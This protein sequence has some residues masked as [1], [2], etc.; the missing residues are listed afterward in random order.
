[1]AFEGD[2]FHD[3]Q[4]LKRD[5]VRSANYPATSRT[6][7]YSVFRRLLPI[8]QTETDANPVIRAQQNPGY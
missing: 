1:L 2:R 4:R 8:P 5:I 3:L 6:V 7:P